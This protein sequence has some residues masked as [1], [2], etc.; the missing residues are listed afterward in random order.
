MNQEQKKGYFLIL[1]A[2]ILWGSIGFFV[3]LLKNTGVDSDAITFIR[4]GTGAVILMPIMLFLGGWKMFIIDLKGLGITL[5]L[6]IFCQAMF[7]FSYS[8]SI[9]NVGIA[10]ASVLLYTSPLFVCIMSKIFFKEMIGIKKICALGIN[11]CG[12][13]LTVTGGEFSSIKFSVY[14]VIAG[15]LAGFL[16]GLMTIISKT[17]TNKY[18]SLTIVFYSFIFGAIALGIVSKPW[19]SI[20][21]VWNASFVLISIGYGFI[22]TVG[23]YFCYMKGLKRDLETSKVPVIASVETIVATIIGI[24]IF[25]ESSSVIKLLGICLVII[26]I[27]IMN[28]K[29]EISH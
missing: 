7:N 1:S 19:D 26:S 25:H 23:A 24:V 3:T 9:N 27:F 13:I 21:A 17:T 10:T 16:Y 14:G 4:I 6:G 11:I 8:E 15:I 18:D 22:P 2:G 28:I 5:I 12:C 29:K 20:G